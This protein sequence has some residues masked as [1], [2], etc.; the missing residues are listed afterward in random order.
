M[1]ILHLA[2]EVDWETEK[3]CFKTISRETAIFYSRISK[4]LPHAEWK[5]TIEYIIYPAI[6]KFLLP[7][8]QLLLKKC[9]Y[10]IANLPNLYKVFER[11]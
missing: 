6:K 5:W 4:T 11:C 10:Q 3:N 7:Q 8:N 2:A 1:F 9:F